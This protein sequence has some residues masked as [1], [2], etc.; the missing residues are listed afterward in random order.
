MR[1]LIASAAGVLAFTILSGAF[2]PA[3][4]AIEAVF[5]QTPSAAV[6]SMKESDPWARRVLD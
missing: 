2:A 1:I 5:D 3:P 4:T 6:A